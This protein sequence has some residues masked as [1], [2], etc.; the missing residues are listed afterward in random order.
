[1]NFFYFYE[2]AKFLPSTI[3]KIQF[4]R[5]CF[6]HSPNFKKFLQR[7][8]DQIKIINSYFQQVINKTKVMWVIFHMS[9]TK[10]NCVFWMYII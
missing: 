7:L 8:S 4:L 5:K 10:L 9:K 3:A 1:M 2:I 6:F